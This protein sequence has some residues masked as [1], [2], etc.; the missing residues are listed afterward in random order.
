MELNL[1]DTNLIDINLIKII[2]PGI[3]EK[4]FRRA[5]KRIS[6][7]SEKYDI[8][9]AIDYEF[10]TKKIAL[11]QIMFQ[12]DKTTN[13]QTNTIPI[14]RFYILYP[15]ELN[16]KTIAYLKRYAMSNLNIIK[17]LH[18]SE[19]LDIPYIVDEFYQQELYNPKKSYRVVNFFM[20]FIDTRYLCEYLNMYYN[21]PNICRIYELLE[22][23]NIIDSKIK[24]KLEQNEKEM[25]PIHELF[26]DI[27][28][29]NNNKPLIIYAIHDV[30]YL[31]DLYKSLKLSII[32]QRPKDYF[33]LIDCL[34]HSFMEK[35]FVSNIGDDIINTNIMNNYFY[36]IMEKSVDKFKKQSKS[37]STIKLI[38]VFDLLIKQYIQSYDSAK[39]IFLIN[40]TK[41]NIQNLLKL[42]LYNII[43]TKYKINASNTEIINYTFNKEVNQLYNNLVLLEMNHLIAFIKQFETYASTVI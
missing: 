32:K 37:T 43:S 6:K 27:N 9:M 41:A 28:K 14:K 11:M 35:R 42:I 12:I 10:N 34:R 38:Q 20:S 15:P 18:G 17:L 21:K 23:Y 13:K 31:V 39:Y 5:L 3:L 25:G 7:L 40:Y 4:K 22:M 24:L 30:V 29:L 16:E 36:T 26:I 1:I 19:A 33:I 8:Y 2:R